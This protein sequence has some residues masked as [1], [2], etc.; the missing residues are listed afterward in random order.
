MSLLTSDY[1]YELPESLIARHPI[2]HRDAARMMVLHRDDQRIEHRSFIDFPTYL[3]DGDIVVLND[4]KVIP[5]RVLIDE[6]RIELLFLEQLGPNI[7]K[8]MVKPG[9]KLRVGK[10]FDLRGNPGM[11]HEILSPHGERIIHFRNHVN[12]EKVGVM[13]LPPYFGRQAEAGDTERYQTVFAQAPGAIAAPTAG[14]HFTPAILERI[15]HTF[16]TL[17]V[18][19]GTFKP[20]QVGRITDHPMHAE[21][22][23]IGESAAREINAAKRIV[24]V[25]TTTVRVLESCMQRDGKITTQENSTDIFIHPPFEFRA[26]DALLTNF[27]LPKSTLL[28]LVCAFAGRE[29]AMCAYAEAIRERYR[30]YSY[31]DCMLIC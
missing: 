19:V 7:W 27:H 26:V 14:L 21:R 12:L 17:H 22:F 9:R 4:T 20:V 16:I 31:G 29:F 24:A 28:M 5:A 8:C 10:T 15:P 30:F 3:R 18:G 11:V 6:G 25:G 23:V 2:P 1:D 13:P